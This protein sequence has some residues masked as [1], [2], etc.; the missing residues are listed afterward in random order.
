[1]YKGAAFAG[2]GAGEGAGR[3]SLVIVRSSRAL[4]D[5]RVGL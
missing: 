1:M 2:G 5:M 3:A 4:V